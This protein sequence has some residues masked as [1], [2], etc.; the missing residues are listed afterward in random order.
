MA[1]GR[2]TYEDKID[3]SV[4]QQD[5]KYKI[6]AQDMNEIK[7][8]FNESAEDIEFAT[9]NLGEYK[10]EN[11]V[12]YFK[13]ADGS[14]NEQGVSLAGQSTILDGNGNV[15]LSDNITPNDNLLTNSDFKSGIIN[16]KGQTE[17]VNT[18]Y[19]TILTVDGW[20][21]DY[22]KV[23]VY[24]KSVYFDNNGS[25]EHGFK[26]PLNLPNE[27]Y[28]FYLDCAINGNARV[29]ARNL[30]NE[31]VINESISGTVKKSFTFTNSLKFITIIASSGTKISFNFMKLEKGSF[32]TGMPPW[33]YANEVSKCHAKLIG[34]GSIQDSDVSIGS[35]NFFN[36]EVWI[37]I[38]LTNY[39][40]KKPTV[41]S[42]G[43]IKLILDGYDEAT[44]TNLSLV[45]FS[46]QSAIV[47]GTLSKSFAS[48]NG[49][50]GRVIMTSGS[51]IIFDGNNY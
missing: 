2:I 41:Y 50:I 33:N 17:Y 36:S 4:N 20:F 24:E 34:L 42:I 22:G 35:A 26:Q 8:V 19:K 25:T 6:T 30:E 37:V 7:Q 12:I 23:N 5:P 46:N 32:F 21:T 14:Y 18:A 28:T 11:G 29:F 10:V 27:T 38:P 51:I 49:K 48:H 39:F 15:I 47:K 13:K 3:S 40:V 1:I 9:E 45:A 43:T 16:Q 44:I 31:E